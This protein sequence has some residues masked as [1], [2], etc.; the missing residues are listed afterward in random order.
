M[1]KRRRHAVIRLDNRAVEQ[2]A[3]VRRRH[4]RRLLRCERTVGADDVNGRRDRVAVDEP[5]WARGGARLYYRC[6]AQVWAV[7]LESAAGEVASPVAVRPG[8]RRVMSSPDGGVRAASLLPEPQRSHLRGL[9]GATDSDQGA[10]A[11]PRRGTPPSRSRPRLDGRTRREGRPR[12]RP[13]GTG[14]A[15]PR[16]E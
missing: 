7:D 2:I 10:P 9:T 16:E 11:G 15:R 12:R 14:A 8:R 4:E 5:L 6:E 1:A 3:G 13:R